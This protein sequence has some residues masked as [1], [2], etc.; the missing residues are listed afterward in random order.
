[1]YYTYTDADGNRHI[2]PYHVKKAEDYK[3][4]YSHSAA[5]AFLGNY[6]FRIDFYSD[7]F[8]VVEYTDNEGSGCPSENDMHDGITR[9]VMASVQVPMPF[10]K[11]LAVWLTKM[12]EEHEGR[13][14]PIQMPIT[15]EPSGEVQKEEPK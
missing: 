9:R 8:P 11:E 12:V 2:V 6:H 4:F 7:I 1:L 5:G 13:Y 10:L 3:E 14:G 15:G